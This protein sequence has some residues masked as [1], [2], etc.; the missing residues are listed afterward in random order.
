MN[1]KGKRKR[2]H[3]TP[4]VTMDVRIFRSISG[5]EPL[6]DRL[7]GSNTCSAHAGHKRPA[8]ARAGRGTVQTQR[9][10]ALKALVDAQGRALACTD[11]GA[12][13]HAEPAGMS[14][15][16][17]ERTPSELL[18]PVPTQCVFIQNA[19]S[20]K[21][22]L[23]SLSPA[24]SPRASLS[25]SRKGSLQVSSG[26]NE[27]FTAWD[28]QLVHASSHSLIGYCLT[29]IWPVL[30]SDA[31]QAERSLARDA[32]VMGAAVRAAERRAEC[33]KA[34]PSDREA[35]SELQRRTDSLESENAQLKTR[36]GEA[37]Q[38][39]RAAGWK[40]RAKEL[41]LPQSRQPAHHP[42]ERA[43]TIDPPPE[44]SSPRKQPATDTQQELEDD[45]LEEALMVAQYQGYQVGSLPTPSSSSKRIGTSQ[46]PKQQHHS[47]VDNGQSPMRKLDMNLGAVNEGGG[48][49]PP[50]Q[51]QCTPSHSNPERK[52]MQQRKQ[53]PRSHT[54]QQLSQQQHPLEWEREA[55][56]TTYG[57]QESMFELAA[58]QVHCT[59]DDI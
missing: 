19:S 48:V 53:T 25:L 39:L 26:C 50:L 38:L 16:E 59:K 49:Y 32:R 14:E 43:K 31:E 40:E 47:I 10:M 11:G 34:G 55:A 17:S 28:S 6:C 3:L 54:K 18:A 20:S 15:R 7:K 21:P 37:A 51:Q 42:I 23:F 58:D 52:G 33:H 41:E 36:L 44:P 12:L 2:L 35:R 4:S 45:E 46:D 56:L 8:H 24:Y 27:I 30:A 5:S 1:S 9:R 22:G 29:D 57:S 13:S